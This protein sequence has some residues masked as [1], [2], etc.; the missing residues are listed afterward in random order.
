M[1]PML[2]ER[3]PSDH[4]HANSQVLD[5]SESTRRALLRIPQPQLEKGVIVY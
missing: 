3:L 1:V 4:D 5:I 2:A